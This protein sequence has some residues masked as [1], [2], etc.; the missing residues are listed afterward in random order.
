MDMADSCERFNMSS[1]LQELDTITTRA[2]EGN[3]IDIVDTTGSGSAAG[4]R[5]AAD[6]S[7][8]ENIYNA[9]G[10]QIITIEP[11]KLSPTLEGGPKG[12]AAS[13]RVTRKAVLWI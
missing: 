2:S 11:S 5:S 9:L 13:D 8:I 10:S 3:I 4:G 1:L 6:V 7:Y 12:E